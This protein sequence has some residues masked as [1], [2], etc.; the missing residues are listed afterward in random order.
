MPVLGGRVSDAWFAWERN[1]G[2]HAP[3]AAPAARGSIAL[4]WHTVRA[5]AL[6]ALRCRDLELF[7]TARAHRSVLSFGGYCLLHYSDQVIV[8]HRTVVRALFI[9][10]DPT[11][12]T[13]RRPPVPRRVLG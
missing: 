1:L 3:P 13:T 10:P 12:T 11:T 2:G 5:R 8:A 7:G 6:T 9:D 4:E